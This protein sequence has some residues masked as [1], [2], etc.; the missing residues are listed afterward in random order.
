MSIDLTGLSAKQLGALIKNAKKQQTVVAK[1]APIAKVRTQLTRAAKA[2]GYSI[3]ELFGA[4]AS[5]G[6]GR[7]AAAGK[8]GPRAGRK[9]GKV[10]PKYRNPANAQETWT[11]RGK[12]PRWLAELT[13]AGKKVEDFLIKKDGGA[14]PAKKA[15]AKKATRKTATKRATKK[16]K[17]A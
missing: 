6:P 17:A 3:E 2:Q 11:G 4:A 1:R 15:T 5:A 10:A 12:Q 9:L 7:P 13:A 16:A 14:K 8:P